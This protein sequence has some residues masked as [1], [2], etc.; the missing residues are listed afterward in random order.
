MRMVKQGQASSAV[1]PSI[2]GEWL[3]RE[4]ASLS[5]LVR[6]P[7]ELRQYFIHFAFSK[8]ML[9]THPGVYRRI[10]KEIVGSYSDGLNAR[11]QKR[12]MP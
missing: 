11:L 8:S 6:R 1:V 7:G 10:N 12:L 5:G 4:D 9:E 3:L 2:A